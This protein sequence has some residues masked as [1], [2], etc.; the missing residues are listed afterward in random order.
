MKGY[1]F[2]SLIPFGLPVS[3]AVLCDHVKSLDWKQRGAEFAGKAPG[4][5]LDDVRERLRPLLGL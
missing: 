3:G 4:P 2:E 1:P 5:L